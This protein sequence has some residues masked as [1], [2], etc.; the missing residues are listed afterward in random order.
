M[1]D[2]GAGGSDNQAIRETRDLL[3]ESQKQSSY[4]LW[5]AIIATI[6]AIVQTA[7]IVLK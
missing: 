6:M 5:L 7:A 3:K 2:F 1:A 4:M